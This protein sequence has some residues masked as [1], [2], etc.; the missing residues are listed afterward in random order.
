M[1]RTPSTYK[2][3]MNIEGVSSGDIQDG[4][5]ESRHIGE[6]EIE[7]KHIADGVIPSPGSGGATPPFE[8][9]FLLRI[10][11]TAENAL[12][13]SE[14]DGIRPFG[15]GSIVTPFRIIDAYLISKA[16]VADALAQLSI[17]SVAN[18]TINFVTLT[19]DTLAAGSIVRVDPA[20]A[21]GW[22]DYNGEVVAT[23]KIAVY[24]NDA[25]DRWELVLTCVNI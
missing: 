25:A 24:A 2:P 14:G 18:G 1:P 5:I 12:E 9:P 16:P 8:S 13:A 4:A 10:E 19:V 20:F 21:P 6:G 22:G 17:L 7:A 23:D 11:C 15:T 3:D